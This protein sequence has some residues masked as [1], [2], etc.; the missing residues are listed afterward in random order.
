[1]HVWMIPANNVRPFDP[2][3]AFSAGA[4]PSRD[5]LA[6]Q[7]HPL[8]PPPPPSQPHHHAPLSLTPP[9]ALQN[10]LRADSPPPPLAPQTPSPRYP[11]PP[12]PLPSPRRPPNR[13]ESHMVVVEEGEIDQSSGRGSGRGRDNYDFNDDSYPQG[14]AP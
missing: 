10:R 2:S 3:S 13:V 8:P 9:R 7:R 6:S 12:P 4:R 5:S 1:M 11:P 14:G